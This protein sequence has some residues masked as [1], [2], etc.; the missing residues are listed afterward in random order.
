MNMKMIIERERGRGKEGREKRGKEREGERG[1]GREREGKM[2]E[3]GRRD[4]QTN[5][6]REIKN[7]LTE[8]GRARERDLPVQSF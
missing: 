5:A 2:G 8:R 4:R 3:R 6:D 1:E 7:V